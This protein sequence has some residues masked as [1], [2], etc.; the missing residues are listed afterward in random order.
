MFG[1][2]TFKSFTIDF[3][4]PNG[5]HV[6]SSGDV[7]SGRIIFELSKEITVNSITVIGKGK[8]KVAW[9]TGS[10][11]QR[12]HYSAREDY[13]NM[14]S[15]IIQ[16]NGAI[17]GGETVLREGTHVYPFSM[18]LPQGHFPSAFQGVHGRVTYALVVQIHRPWH[19]AEEFRAELNFVSHIDA[20]HPQLLE[21]LAASNSK[22]L[23]CLCC[24]SGPISMNAGLERKGYVPGEMIQIIAEFENS[25]SRTI[26]PTATLVQTQTLREGISCPIVQECGATKCCGYLLIHPSPS[27]T[28][29][30]WRWTTICR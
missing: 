3:D 23:C 12:R 28:A 1:D 16:Q 10:S 7:V 8:A 13:F 21:P 22:E 15:D 18:Q 6:F 24:T 19:L 11:K 5:I 4:A 2:K 27:Q 14:K 30:F 9:S 25:S 20:N 26:I 17:G 29:R